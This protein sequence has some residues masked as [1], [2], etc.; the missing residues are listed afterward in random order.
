MDDTQGQYWIDVATSN[1]LPQIALENASLLLNLHKFDLIRSHLDVVSDGDNGDVTLIRLLVAPLED[2][3]VSE[4][5]FST[6]KGQLKRMKWLDPFTTDLVMVK[7]PWLGVERGEIITA[8]CSL[9]HPVMAKKNSFVFSKANILDTVTGDRY[10]F[11]AASI[12]DLFQERFD[13]ENSL[14]DD[15]LKVRSDEIRSTID[16]SVIDTTHREILHKMVDIVGHTLKTNLYLENRYSL[17]LRLNPKIMTDETNG[18]REVPYGIFFAHGRRFN[19]FHVRFR[20]IARGGMRLVTPNSPE[21][22]ALESARQYDECYGLAFAQQM[23]NKDIP[24]GGSKAV[25]LINVDGISEQG[26]NFVM[27][28][29][30]KAFTDTLLDLIVDTEETRKSMVDFVGKKEVLYLGPDEQV[31]PEDINW[32][33][34]RAGKRGYGTPAAFMSSKPRVGIN[35]KEYGVTSEGVHVYLDVALR[36]CLGIDPKKDPFT[37]KMTGGPDGDVGGNGIKILIREYGDNARIVGI[38]DG[39]GCAEDPDGLD[40]AGLLRLVEE[41]A[42]ISNFDPS[43]LG[44]RGKLWTVDTEEGVKK[45]ND[46]HNRLE[47]DAF[48]PAGGRPNTIDGSNYKQFL[49][50]DGTA[51]SPLIVEA[52]NI[53]ITEEAR[54]ALYDEAGVVIVKD[55]SANKCGVITSSYEIC[56]AMML[57]ED[58]FYD[59]KEQIVKEV[60]EKLRSAAR[61]EAELIFREFDNFPG[62]L[63]YVSK[64]VSDTIN[65]TNDALSSALDSMSEEE[66]ETM[67]PLFRNHLPAT[68]ANLAFDRVRDRVPPQYV[69][70]AISSTL[71]ARIVYREGTNFVRTYPEDKLARIALAYLEKEKETA[72]LMKALAGSADLPDKEKKAILNL[73]DA[74]GARTLLRDT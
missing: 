50:D 44:P 66:W 45:R 3:V 9:I 68:M 28:K 37:I 2:G 56:A 4:E 65:A 40:H 61:M 14:S 24:E 10:I 33:I 22:Y 25:N 11:H 55:S 47:A 19:G 20:D 18:E 57:S 46:M 15:E 54:Q 49:K 26:K 27:R 7:Y 23:K 52:A 36:E 70:N 13:P 21:Q 41:E 63:P 71:A 64:V 32:I 8:F 39:S 42:V 48:I 30:V 58:E 34:K 73:L 31:T 29:S 1:A 17:G 59:N 72:A 43:L 60:L 69:K 67:L 38:A 74:G 62:S 5:T 6:L 51:T 35:H 53:F 12:A 16:N